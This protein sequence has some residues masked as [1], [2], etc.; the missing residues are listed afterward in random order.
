MVSLFVKI[1]KYLRAK[2]KKLPLDAEFAIKKVKDSDYSEI[3]TV[4]KFLKDKVPD[5]KDGLI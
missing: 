2:K 3:M 1:S 5:C 4:Y